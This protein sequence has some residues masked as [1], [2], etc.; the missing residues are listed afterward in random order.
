MTI[1]EYEVKLQDIDL[2]NEVIQYLTFMN[3]AWK[4]KNI[5]VLP[6]PEPKSWQ[7]KFCSHHK[8]C[9][10]EGYLKEQLKV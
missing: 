1:Q 9:V 4:E 5:M 10:D 7:E 6:L 8:K 3:K 2:A